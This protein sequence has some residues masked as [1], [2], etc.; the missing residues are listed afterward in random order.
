MFRPFTIENAYVFRSDN[1]RSLF[2]RISEDERSLLT[3]NPETF[4]WYNYWLNIH[5]PGLTKWVFPTLE[6]EM[7][8]AAKA[9]LHLSRSSRTLRDVN[10][11]SRDA[12]RNAYR[13]RRTKGTVHLPGSG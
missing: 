7:R 12:R 11:A 8:S 4:D 3:W 1:V 5:L 6:D 2:S 10:Q 9:R 13:T